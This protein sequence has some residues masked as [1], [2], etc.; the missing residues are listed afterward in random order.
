MN[1]PESGYE[2]HFRVSV[3]PGWVIGCQTPQFK[4]LNCMMLVSLVRSFSISAGNMAEFYR[5][6]W[7]GWNQHLHSKCI[8]LIPYINI[9]RHIAFIVSWLVEMKMSP[10]HHYEFW[11]TSVASEVMDSETIL[12]LLSPL[13]QHKR[14]YLIPF[15]M[16]QISFSCIESKNSRELDLHS[17]F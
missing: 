9:L 15:L 11:L 4:V 5:F 8:G 1:L 3:I 16:V 7:K 17:F 12:Y 10:N 13:V 6:H 14:Y 2:S